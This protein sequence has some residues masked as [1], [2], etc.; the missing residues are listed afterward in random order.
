[1]RHRFDAD[2][3]LAWQQIEALSAQ[4]ARGARSAARKSAAKGGAKSAAGKTA[5]RAR[6]S[7]A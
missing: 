6:K 2:R 1:M 5:K 7:A 3:D 4:V